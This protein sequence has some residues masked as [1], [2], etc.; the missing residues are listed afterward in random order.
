M[1]YRTSSPPAPLERVSLIDADFKKTAFLNAIVS[2]AEVVFEQKVTVDQLP[3]GDFYTFELPGGRIRFRAYS[4]D[5]VMLVAVDEAEDVLARGP[6]AD[7]CVVI[8]AY[9][10]VAMRRARREV[11]AMRSRQYD[12]ARTHPLPKHK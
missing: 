7:L 5:Q 10:R 12:A 8:D 9:E 11:D 1:V 2:Q 4:D 6:A 3:E